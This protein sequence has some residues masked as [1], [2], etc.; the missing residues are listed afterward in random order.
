M[1]MVSP[2]MQKKMKKIFTQYGVK[3]AYLFGSRATGKGITEGSD[4]DIAVFFGKGTSR[5]RLALRFAMYHALQELFAPKRID[6]IVLD[7][8]HSVT[9]R[10]SITSEG[11]LIYERDAAARLDFAF[12]ALH[13]YEDF[14]PFLRA[15]NAAYMAT[16]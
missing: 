12:R 5:T 16:V 6:C 2:H 1:R 13:E 8:V 7:D 10:Y 15:Y 14:A 9:L 11:V 3:F 4:V